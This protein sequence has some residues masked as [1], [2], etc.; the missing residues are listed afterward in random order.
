MASS[1]G[2]SDQP[3]FPPVPIVAIGASA[4]GLE[5]V[6][7]LLQHLSPTTGLAYVY[8]QHLSPTHESQLTDILSQKTTMPVRE[9]RHRMPVQANH[10]YIIPPNKGMVVADGLLKLVPRQPEPAIPLP[11]DQFFISLA[12]RQRAASIAIVLSGTASDGTLGLKAIKAAGGITFAQ[13]N[14]AKFQG[15]PQSAQAEGVVDKV[16]SPREIAGELD[17]LSR[18]PGL[19][20]QTALLTEDGE[21]PPVPAETET[22]SGDLSALLQLLQLLRKIIGVDFSHYKM[23]TIRR[24]VV[25]RMALY[26]L[27]ALP[28]YTA[29]LRQHPAEA[30]LLYND[31]LINVTSFFRDS[32]TMDYLG[33]VV[34][35]QLLRGKPAN[36]PFRLWVTACSTGEEVYSLAML[37]L[38][39][40]DALEKPIPIQIFATDLSERVISRA[41][42]G[43]YTASQL[44]EVSAGRRQRFFTQEA[45]TFRISKVVRD[46]CVFAPHNVFVDP[47]FSRMD[48]ISCRNLLIYTDNSLQRK[49]IATFHYALNTTGYLLLGKAETVGASFSLFTQVAKNHKLYARKNN[50]SRSVMPMVGYGYTAEAVPLSWPPALTPPSTPP[51]ENLPSPS[52]EQK[53]L[54]TELTGIVPCRPLAPPTIWTN[55]LTSY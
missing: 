36:E 6:S 15:M 52:G 46:L 26:K 1:P 11:I 30:G 19:F 12:N 34:L 53:P 44:T 22:E 4:G 29:Y 48:L 28:A 40:L 10:V 47:P 42:L 25:R 38:E 7:D 5:A 54:T 8:I 14:S 50:G 17:W 51:T 27:P 37:L 39:A 21:D 33:N 49:A 3:Q 23:A 13:D 2:K 41:R 32:E 18:Q 20:Q 31:L 55:A 45:D 35:P 43:R 16:L 9:A 24:R